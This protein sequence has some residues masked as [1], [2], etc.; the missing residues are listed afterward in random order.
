M[1]KLVLLIVSV[2]FCLSSIA[3]V[4]HP[5][6][7]T[8]KDNLKTTL[9]YRLK[10]G[11]YSMCVIVGKDTLSMTEYHQKYDNKKTYPSNTT[12]TQNTTVD[13]G[14]EIVLRPEPENEEDSID[15]Y[16]FAN[17]G[18]PNLTFNKEYIGDYA[19]DQ[20]LEATRLL[21]KEVNIYRGRF[22]AKSLRISPRIVG[23]ACRWGNYMMSKHFGVYNNFYQH[24]KFGPDEYHIPGN[25][26][27]NIHLIYFDHYPTALEMVYGLMYGIPREGGNVIGWTQSEGHNFNLLQDIVKYYG[28][29][30]Y[31]M[32]TG[33]IYTVYGIQN[34][35][36]TK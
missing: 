1:K 21:Y 12:T 30:V 36:I 24:S 33:K 13:P 10:G 6:N 31:V 22:G 14:K 17:D 3:Q 15:P 4:L 2:T 32:Q 7:K 20:D 18:E 19:I 26:S 16:N 29:A 8:P 23:Y 25:C 9:C 5:D 11:Q 28:V 35:S 27:E 34:F